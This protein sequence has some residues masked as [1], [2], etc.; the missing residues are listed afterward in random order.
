MLVAGTLSLVAVGA[1]VGAVSTTTGLYRSGNYSHRV[2]AE[3]RAHAARQGLMQKDLAAALGYAP[4]QIT[5][6]MRGQVAFTLDEL[7]ALARLF[8][9]EP[10]ELMPA[11]AVR[12]SNPEPADSVP[13][14][15]H[16]IAER[17]ST[18]RPWTTRR[19]AHRPLVL[20]CG[21]AVSVGA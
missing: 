1:T 6:R 8:G 17:R 10:A 9:I 19:P 16:P 3:V 20:I 18:S 5:K 4:S 15:V 7:E 14:T 21:E 11:C 13:A 12:D 2:A